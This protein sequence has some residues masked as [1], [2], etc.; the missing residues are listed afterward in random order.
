MGRKNFEE[1]HGE[2]RAAG[3]GHEKAGDHRRKLQDSTRSYTPV[4]HAVAGFVHPVKD[5]GGYGSCYAFGA[6][7]S[8]EGQIMKIT[9]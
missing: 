4:D 1:I 8:L 5:Q 3:K 2:Q 9:N 6:N 7:T